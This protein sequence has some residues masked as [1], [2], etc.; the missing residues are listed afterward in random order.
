MTVKKKAAIFKA[1]KEAGTVISEMC[2]Q[3]TYY[4]LSFLL[5]FL[6][7]DMCANLY[8]TLVE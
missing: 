6:T 3:F 7:K 1:H 2:F 4:V 5:P 8:L